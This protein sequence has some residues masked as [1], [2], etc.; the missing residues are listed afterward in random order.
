METALK[1]LMP[2]SC[3]VFFG[4]ALL[5][6]L[7]G[8]GSRLRKILAWVMLVWGIIISLRLLSIFTVDHPLLSEKDILS[9][10]SPFLGTCALGMLC[11]YVLELVKPGWINFR[12]WLIIASPYLLVFTIYFGMFFFSK[13]PVIKLNS[14]SDIFVNI[15]YFNVWFRFVPLFLMIGYL[16][17]LGRIILKTKQQYEKWCVDNY[18]DTEAMDLS[19]LSAFF[20]CM[21]LISISFCLVFVTGELLNFFVHRI[22]IDLSFCFFLYKTL[23]HQNPYPEGFFKNTFDIE[24]AEKE[25]VYC[26]KESL[27]LE[28]QEANAAFHEK[29]EV[30]VATIETWMVEQ[31]PHRRKNLKLMD[32]NEILPLNRSYISRVF[33]DGFGESFSQVVQRYRIKEAQQLMIVNPKMTLNEISDLCGFSS[34]TSFNRTFSKIMGLA[35]GE[36]R[37]K[38]SKNRSL[39]EV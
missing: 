39:E 8:E 11:P 24:L 33:N 34:P 37:K 20:V 36:Y 29:L 3:T 5:L 14:L 25:S 30:Y 38:K 2:A 9:P 6:F 21:V 10:L 23:F 4:G 18:A 35:P 31:K 27:C 7:R 16:I 17:L 22:I 12:R 15:G 32:V 13:T 26:Q 28:T 19:W 1:M